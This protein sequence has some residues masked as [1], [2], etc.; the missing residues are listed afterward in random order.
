MP[1]VRM[2]LLLLVACGLV[3]GAGCSSEKPTNPTTP[4]GPDP[5]LKRMD[6]TDGGAKAGTPVE[7][8]ATTIK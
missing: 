2:A 4:N 5:A 6:K 7:K 1:N 8:G 3:S